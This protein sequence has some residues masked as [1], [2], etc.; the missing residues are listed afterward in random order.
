MKT[1]KVEMLITTPRD[2]NR[3]QSGADIMEE[4][5]HSPENDGV[6]RACV[7]VV[8]SEFPEAE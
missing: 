6:P 2:L 8:V 1:W 7:T 5:Y 4:L 3:L